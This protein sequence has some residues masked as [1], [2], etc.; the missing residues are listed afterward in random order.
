MLFQI[1]D[2]KKPEQ[3]LGDKDKNYTFEFE[4]KPE[5]GEYLSLGKEHYKVARLEYTHLKDSSNKM[6]MTVWVKPLTTAEEANLKG[7]S[8]Q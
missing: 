7:R 5:V 8:E 4:Q 3:E 6:R 2:V 1:R